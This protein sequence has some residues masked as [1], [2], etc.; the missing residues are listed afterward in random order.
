MAAVCLRVVCEHDGVCRFL[1]V[2]ELSHCL[3]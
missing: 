2:N 3:S 1:I